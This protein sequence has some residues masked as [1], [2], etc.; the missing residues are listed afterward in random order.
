MSGNIT[1]KDLHKLVQEQ[2]DKS[3]S[4]QDTKTFRNQLDRQEISTLAG[5]SS[6]DITAAQLISSIQ[7]LLKQALPDFIIE[8]L[9]VKATTPPSSNIIVTKGRGSRGGAVFT[10]LQDT[11]VPIPILEQRHQ[12]LYISL[13]KDRIVLDNEIKQEALKLAKIVFPIPGTTFKFYNNASDRP[14]TWQGYIQTYQEFRLYSD[15]Y[16]NLEEDSLEKFRNNIGDILADNLIGNIRLSENLKIINTQGSLEM[17]SSG[18]KLYDSNEELQAKFDRRGTFFYDSNN[19][20][21]ARFTRDDA[22]IGNILI[23]R[24]SLGSS[25]FISED[26]GFRIEDNGYAEFENVRIRG[27]ISSSV[28]EYDKVSSVGGKLYVGNASTLAVNMTALDASTLEVDDAVFAIGDILL[29]KNGTNEEY[30]EVTDISSAP[31]YTVTR[32]LAN[33][34]TS[35]NN[36]TW[37]T[38]TAVVSTGNGISGSLSGFIKLDAVSNY[39][40][41]IDIAQRNSTTYDDY[42]V[43]ARFGNLEG[44]SDSMYGALSGYGLYSDNVYLKGK[45]YAPDIKTAVTGSRIELNTSCMAGYNSADTRTYMFDLATG[46]FCFGNF[47]GGSGAMWDDSTS[48]FCLRASLN[49]CDICAGFMSADFIRGGN[50]Y[51]CSGMTIGTVPDESGVGPERT[52][53]DAQGISSYD[54]T[55]TRNF[56]LCDGHIE[57]RDIKL[58]DPNCICCYSFLDAGKLKFHD[59][60]GP[61]PYVNRICS[62]IANTGD[63]VCLTGWRT[64]PEVIVGIKSLDSYNAAKVAQDQ[65]WNIYADNFTCYCE[66]GFNYGYCFQVHASLNLAVGTGAECLKNTT[67]GTCFCTDA[68]VCSTQVRSKFQLWCHGTAPDNYRYGVLCYAICYRCLGCLVWCASCFCYEHPHASILQMESDG[69]QTQTMNFPCNAQWEIMLC[70]VSLNWTDSGLASGS[71]ICNLCTRTS[72]ACSSGYTT[73]CNNTVDGCSGASITTCCSAACITLSG[74]DPSNVYCSYFCYCWC[75]NSTCHVDQRF[76]SGAFTSG[77]SKCVV[78]N[79]LEVGLC[80]QIRAGASI[81]SMAT[82][83]IDA[84]PV[85]PINFT[86]GVACLC[87]NNTSFALTCGCANLNT[88]NACGFSYLCLCHQ[89]QFYW[90]Q[91][92]I[93]NTLCMCHRTCSD[94]CVP[95][96]TLYQC[97]CSFSGAAACCVLNCAHSL[98]DTYGTACILDPAGVVNWLAIAY[99]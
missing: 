42:D 74:S 45:L 85:G 89:H 22:R 88:Y 83:A 36:P 39:S 93:C 26:R 10:L 81:V 44:I 13:Y 61:V 28:F 96:G 6:S 82:C 21:V 30:L 37:S 52:T 48:T 18:I 84:T 64:Q 79:Q 73:T 98:C 46:D 35:N 68:S 87:T 70:Q 97:Y 72:T 33:S 78:L 54:N 25:N 12:V 76:C 53:F 92:G 50:L 38:G 43:K 32:D 17:D 58:Q 34:F 19:S 29:I 66:S 15:P 51:L 5:N 49:A 31:I 27:K 23:T 62:G 1:Y 41:F 11:V 16:D 75:T 91:C 90:Y 60:L 14:D 57:A 55:G 63:Y 77:G 56:F 67:F 94:I 47:S 59:E 99:T 7:T 20:E 95:S 65:R 4:F 9:V 24:N 86:D 2:I 80:L 71:V 8:G 3:I 40:P 69:E